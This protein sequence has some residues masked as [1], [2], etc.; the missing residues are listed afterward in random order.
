MFL[1]LCDLPKL[2][3]RICCCAGPRTSTVTHPW[4]K[5]HSLLQVAVLANPWAVAATTITTL[6]RLSPVSPTRP[7][8]F[9]F[10]ANTDPH[11]GTDTK[12]RKT[13]AVHSAK[14]QVCVDLFLKL[15][16]PHSL[17]PSLPSWYELCLR[18]GHSLPDVKCLPKNIRP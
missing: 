13:R 7:G 9:L 14:R 17:Y 8:G 1:V 3:K 5:A 11:R 10:P 18:T 6:A 12:R 15:S 16:S 2:T 4:P